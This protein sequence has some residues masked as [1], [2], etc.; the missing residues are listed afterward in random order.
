[1]KCVCGYEYQEEWDKQKKC[2]LPTVGDE[3]FIK[4][5]TKATVEESG[6]HR[7]QRDVALHIC[8]KCGTVRAT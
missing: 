2:F 4:I 3:K 6:Y 1:M 7:A 8:P 5:D